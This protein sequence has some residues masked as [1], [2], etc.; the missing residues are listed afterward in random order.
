M[1][2]LSN[3]GAYISKTD[4]MKNFT[5]LDSLLDLFQKFVVK[6]RIGASFEGRQ[7]SQDILN[8]LPKRMT[9]NDGNVQN[10][11][12]E[13]Q[14]HYNIKSRLFQTMELYSRILREQCF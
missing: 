10:K 7:P 2:P 1:G 14:F 13:L 6:Y 9:N 12:N 5:S 8:V 3:F 11:S 4:F